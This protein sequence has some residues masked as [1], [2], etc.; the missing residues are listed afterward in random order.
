[1]KL[2]KFIKKL[3][4]IKN[5]EGDNVEIIMADNIPV[6]GPV[7]LENFANRKVVIITDEK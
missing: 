5:R 3:Q 1:M 7:F 6:V 2:N 4:E